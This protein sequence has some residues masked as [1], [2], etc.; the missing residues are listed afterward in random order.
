MTSPEQPDHPEDS[1]NTGDAPAE[2]VDAHH[3]IWRK[4]DLPWLDGE[5]VPR[6]FG[7]YEPIRRDYPADEYVAEATACGISSSVYV[8]TNWPLERSVDEVR[9]LRDV[10]AQTGW[11]MAV[12]GSA[13][14][15]DPGAAEVMRH[16][17]ELTPLMRGTRL[18]LHW[19]DRPEFRF[20]SAPDRMNDP[21]FRRNIATLAELGWLFELQVFAPQMADAAAFVADFPDITFVLVHAGMLDGTEP[22]HVAEWTRG[23]R[24]LAEQP[25]VVVKLTGQ[26]TFVHR[27]DQ[28]LIDLVTSAC[29]E[30]FGSRRCMWGSNFPV[31]KLWTDLPTLVRAWRRAL[32]R[33]APD[34]RRD[35]F[36]ETARR[37]YAL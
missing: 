13:D 7:P 9:W 4:A 29:L 34:I 6:I 31:E 1:E 23:M 2:L 33:Y 26:G 30:M 22:S 32:D 10:N 24:L 12:I 25:N 5:M 37:V 16:Q 21:V 17:A 15:F 36:T 8:Q 35:V 3:H 20:A 19:H 28:A 11:P 18:Q 27:V 14:L